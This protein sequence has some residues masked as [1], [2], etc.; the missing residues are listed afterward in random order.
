MYLNTLIPPG[1]RRISY[2]L[3]GQCASS[4]KYSLQP[5]L[6][7][8]KM[9][10][11]LYVVGVVFRGNRPQSSLATLW[12]LVFKS[13]SERAEAAP[14]LGHPASLYFLHPWS[15]AQ[16]SARP[17]EDSC[18]PAHHSHPQSNFNCPRSGLDRSLPLTPSLSLKRERA[19]MC[20]T[21][22]L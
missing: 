14:R 10:T 8:R 12:L 15:R 16:H 22:S 21:Q 13:P 4:Q 19:S 5:R 3:L 1:S 7:D 2:I 20:T 17:R 9:E 6:A 18:L 11:T